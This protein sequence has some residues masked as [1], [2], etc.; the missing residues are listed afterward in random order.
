[1]RLVD[2]AIDLVRRLR[3][4]GLDVVC[5][6]GLDESHFERH[7]GAWRSSFTAPG[8]ICTDGFR[9]GIREIT[10][11][12]FGLGYPQV[13][14]IDDAARVAERARELRVPFVGHPSPFRHGFQRQA[15]QEI[16]VRHLVH[17]LSDIDEALLHTLDREAAQD[18]VWQEG[19]RPFA[20][21]GA[22][23]REERA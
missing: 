8:Y 16:G 3:G 11:D 7:I 9:P 6:G 4:L 10:Q 13:V 18:T 12:R 15:M 14:F 19:D 1:M 20:G 5:Y 2:G 21:A 23:R 17:R 22:E